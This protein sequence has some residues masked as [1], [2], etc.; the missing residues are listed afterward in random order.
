VKKI[1]IVGYGVIGK[2]VADAVSL[3]N[4][5]EICGIVETQ[6]TSLNSILVL[7]GYPLFG[8][9]E[10]A[11]SAMKEGGYPVIGDLHD[12]L[13]IADLVVDATPA[14]I[15]RINMPLYA[16]AKVPVI[17]NGGEKADTA[18]VS[19]NALENYEA[20]Y[21][22]MKVRV[23]SC[24][25]TAI[26]RV[27]YALQKVSKISESHVALVRR[28]AD[29]VKTNKGPINAIIPVLGGFSHHAD[30]V[31]T[32]FPDLKIT[33]LA[34]ATS[35]TLSHVH[36]FKASF[37]SE[38]SHEAVIEALAT[39]PRIVLIDGNMGLKDDA[40]IKE[41]YKDIGRPRGDM[42]EVAVWKDSIEV[43]S[44]ELSLIYNVH[45]ESIPVPGHIDAVRSMLKIESDAGTSVKATDQS[46]GCSSDNYDY[47][48]RKPS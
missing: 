27:I 42:W 34:V 14:G 25:T 16:A 46:L 3:Q 33:S 36:M 18:D 1:L 44:N 20:A 22:R 15:A 39:T 45:M 6:I 10:A 37:E 48:L 2:R 5:M 4:D 19:F 13:R 12:G 35:A 24:N 38:F 41:Y 47:D 23:V 17:I 30:D 21:G 28:A 29:P 11:V 32:I 40:Q 43:V 26:C 9:D 31:R 7:K 8:Y